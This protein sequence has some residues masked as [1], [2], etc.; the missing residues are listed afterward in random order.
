MNDIFEVILKWCIFSM[1]QDAAFG[2]IGL[3]V[4]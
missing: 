3:G 1:S 2:S 4:Y